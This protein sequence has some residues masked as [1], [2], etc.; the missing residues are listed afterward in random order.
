MADTTYTPG[1]LDLTLQ[2]V[3]NASISSLDKVIKRLTT[4]NKLLGKTTT[5]T[6]GGNVVG[7]QSGTSGANFFRLAKFSSAIFLA[8][9]L[10]KS[11]ANIVQYGSNFDE[12]LNMW[13]VAFRNNLDAAD[14]FISKMHTA[15]GISTQV[16]MENQAIYK[17]MLSQMGQLSEEASYSLSESLTRM[18][19]DYS[20]LWN[21]TIQSASEKFKAMLAG[22]IRPIRSIS[23]ISVEEQAIYDIYKSMGGE[24]TMRQLTQVEKRLLRIYA[25]FYQM[26]QS[27][28]TGDFAKTIE[29]FANQSR[30]MGEYWKELVTWIGLGAKELIETSG[31]M[32]YIN[33]ALIFTTEII[34]ALFKSAG[35]EEENYLDGIFDSS[36][37]ANESVD[38][39]QGKLLG[40]DKFRSL[41]DSAGQGNIAIDEKVIELLESYNS[42]LDSVTNKA[43]ELATQWLEAF[44]F[45]KDANGEFEISTDRLGEIKDNLTSI[46]D[47]IFAIIG[48]NILVR[49]ISLTTA[50]AQSVGTI[51]KLN[52]FI[53]AAVTSF[54]LL[55]GLF[56]SLDGDAKK[57]AVSL[58]AIASTLGLIAGLALITTEGL[59]YG[60]AGAIVTG[61]S[62]GALIASLSEAAIIEPYANGGMPDK[63]TVFLAGE[64]GAEIVS[65]SSS[66]Q[67]GVANVDQIAQAT[68][69]GNMMFWAQAKR[70]LARFGN[71]TISADSEGIF[72]VVQGQAQKRGMSFA[73]SK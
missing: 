51:G 67:T 13:Q 26:E 35:Y 34:K 60:I 68:Y 10:G 19:L 50:L 32:Q 8:R 49:V 46:R 11:L 62:V 14:K 22:Q 56:A 6:F 55:T 73:K 59:K 30:L 29:K 18:M 61:T 58:T 69:R 25:T 72:K 16:L 12:T 40:F 66:G 71:V 39:L 53:T 37:E 31:I 52:L 45:T 2:S 7:R 28:A 24:K 9:R 44:G 70:D 43:Q 48:A 63:G 64:A 4:I 41:E 5:G 36:E 33:A 23:G 57:L 38:K 27:G 54:S 21:T 42:T 1:N 47:I 15:Y 65:S 3:S 17:N 20:S